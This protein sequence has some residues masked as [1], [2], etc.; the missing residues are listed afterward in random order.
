MAGH[1]DEEFEDA[2]AQEPAEGTFQQCIRVV[3]SG[4]A[5]K[6]DGPNDP[7]TNESKN[8]T[9]GIAPPGTTA[10]CGLNMEGVERLNSSS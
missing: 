1:G 8:G 4:K 5:S 10:L 2:A 9:A 3:L 7:E 6:D